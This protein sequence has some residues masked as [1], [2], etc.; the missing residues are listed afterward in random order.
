MALQEKK[1]RWGCDDTVKGEGSLSSYLGDSGHQH[2]PP[3]ITP[4]HQCSLT[5][6]FKVHGQLV[7]FFLRRLFFFTWTIFKAFIKFIIILLPY[8]VLAF[9][10]QG[11]WDLSSPLRNQTLTPS[12]GRRS[13]NHRTARE[14]PTSVSLYATSPVFFKQPPTT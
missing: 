7:S 3:L 14:V 9:W 10:P 11:M 5:F 8:D 12:T 2:S 1:K 6:T 4:S 13:L